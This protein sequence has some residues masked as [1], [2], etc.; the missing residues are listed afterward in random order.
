ME[1]KK[2]NVFVLALVA[3]VAL[4]GVWSAVIELIKFAQLPEWNF[5]A[6]NAIA[7]LVY[8]LLLYYVFI[9]YKK[10]HGNLLRY[11]LLAFALC[12]A[13]TVVFLIKLS[14]DDLSGKTTLIIAAMMITYMAGRLNKLRQNIVIM[15]VVA[16]LLAVSL[17]GFF[18]AFGFMSFHNTYAVICFVI[19]WIMLCA[20]YLVRFKEHKEAGLMDA[21]KE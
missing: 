8:I 11:L 19:Q 1:K 10:P 6:L 2:Q 21:P 7:I 14:F 15:I 16:I 3:L 5:F 20:A 12:I 17:I 9:G 18:K 4:A 13:L